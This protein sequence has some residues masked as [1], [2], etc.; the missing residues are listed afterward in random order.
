MGTDLYGRVAYYTVMS[1][2]IELFVCCCNLDFFWKLDYT[3]YKLY[4][5]PHS[6]IIEFWHFTFRS[7]DL[8]YNYK[9]QVCLATNSTVDHS[10]PRRQS[11]YT[12]STTQDLSNKYNYIANKLVFHLLSVLFLN[13]THSSFAVIYHNH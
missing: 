2:R 7:S 5:L 4:P 13:I 12:G 8:G 9:L 10:W 11:P 3:T 6:Y 1:L